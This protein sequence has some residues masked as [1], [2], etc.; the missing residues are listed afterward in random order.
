M[1][2][3]GIHLVPII[4]AA[5]KIEDG[6]DVYVEGVRDNH[7]CKTADGRDFT[8]GVWPGK[9]HF[10]DFLNSKTRKWFG[11]KYKTLVDDGIEVSGT[12]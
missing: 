3:E 4:D 5:V 12:I 9:T 2:E 8:A 7:F 11:D 6:Y 10:P 1:R